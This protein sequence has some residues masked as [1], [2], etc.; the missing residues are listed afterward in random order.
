MS[1]QANVHD[2]AEQLFL[3]FV[4]LHPDGKGC[5]PEEF[6]AQTSPEV[7]AE[8]SLIVEDFLALQT[9][10][11]SDTSS[12][13]YA[14]PQSGAILGDFRLLRELGRGG[15]GVV[16]Q[17]EQQTLQREVALK[18]LYPYLGLADRW[19]KRFELEAQVGGRLSHPGVVQVYAIGEA[20]GQHFI[21]Q[22][23]VPGGR[24]LAHWFADLAEGDALP[25]G[26]FQTLAEVFLC[27]A[28]GLVAAHAAGVIHRDVKPG[29]ILL[30]GEMPKIA[31]F[32]LAWSAESSGL[33]MTGETLG[34]PYYM[35]PEQVRGSRERIDPRTDVY[36]LGATLYEGLVFR[37]PFSGDTRDQVMGKI[38]HQEA[39]DPRKLRSKVPRD[40]AVICMK[41]MEKAPNHRFASMQEFAA[42]LRRYLQDQPIHARPP[43]RLQRTFKWARRHPATSAGGTVAAFSLVALV[44]LFLHARAGW[45][46]AESET[47]HAVRKQLTAERIEDFMVELFRAIGPGGASTPD[48]PARDFLDFGVERAHSD[49]S[50]EA[51]VQA[52]LLM[53]W[54][55]VYA[56][57]GE[58]ERAETLLR[59][60]LDLHQQ[61]LG[62][63]DQRTLKAQNQLAHLL[64]QRAKYQDAEHFYRLAQAGH[65][66]LYGPNS[67]QALENQ[68]NLAQL[69]WRTDRLDLAEPLLANS[70]EGTRQIWGEDHFHTW[71]GRNNLAAL[72]LRRG[73]AA[74]A[75]PL[76]EKVLH[77]RVSESGP[78]S[79]AAIAVMALLAE[80]FRAQQMWSQAEAQYL[81]VLAAAD[82]L[83]SADHPSIA[84][85]RHSYGS[86]LAELKRWPEAR[87]QF[88]RAYEIR[89]KKLRDGHPST[90]ATLANLIV[91]LQKL[92]RKTEALALARDLVVATPVED[93]SYSRRKK[94]LAALE[95]ES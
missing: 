72:L 2:Q 12:V 88:Q 56:S 91:V 42:D 13:R 1:H 41:S 55:M 68:G 61:V 31:D 43:G 69:Y 60:A 8:F 49:L 84:G 17:A 26:Y 83:Y 50:D 19:L 20:E 63:V 87:T 71:T 10:R 5:N 74:L 75:Q 79:Q 62:A 6:C 18:V 36:S 76:L 40:L 3:E 22:E 45:D 66:E 67:A 78:G 16:W 59:E 51:E 58:N 54:G 46:T 64:V 48:T 77:K 14:G 24:T 30:E 38:L 52:A 70:L 94:L 82:K 86:L 7:Q 27:I 92:N 89:Q 53:N 44:F 4:Q 33:S 9:G 65:E 37:P 95:G 39:E 11:A 29:N 73:K 23:L 34:T 28:E 93:K 47:A 81:E 90:L 80:A 85:H 32:G 25:S 15:M 57:L 21:A 35:S